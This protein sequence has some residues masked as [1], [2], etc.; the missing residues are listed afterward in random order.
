MGRSTRPKFVLWFLRKAATGFGHR[1]RTSRGSSSTCCSSWWSPRCLSSN[2]RKKSSKKYS[3]I[4]SY[5]IK[6]LSGRILLVSCSTLIHA[7]E[8]KMP[9]QCSKSHLLCLGVSNITFQPLYPDSIANAAASTSCSSASRCTTCPTSSTTSTGP[10]VSTD[11]LL[12]YRKFVA[13]VL[14]S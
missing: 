3:L 6:G 14:V 12:S 10:P 4:I 7:S 13:F 9:D 1:K 2:G 8:M 11:Q 5:F